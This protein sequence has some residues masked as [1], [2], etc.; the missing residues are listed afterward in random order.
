MTAW[1]IDALKQI[2]R[3]PVGGLEE[4]RL[5]RVAQRRSAGSSARRV[6]SRWRMLAQVVAGCRKMTSSRTSRETRVPKLRGE[7]I[8]EPSAVRSAQAEAL[9]GSFAFTLQYDHVLCGFP[10]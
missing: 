5:D 7:R 9:P 10:G 6:R 2:Q 1:S 4:S 8:R 3:M